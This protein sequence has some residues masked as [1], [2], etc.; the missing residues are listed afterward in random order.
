M[1]GAFFSLRVGGKVS[2]WNPHPRGIPAAA[3]HGADGKLPGG[4][5]SSQPQGDHGRGGVQPRCGELRPWDEGCG[6]LRPTTAHKFRGTQF[7]SV[8]IWYF[9]SSVGKKFGPFCGIIWMNCELKDP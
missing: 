1:F 2:G 3:L 5:D 9:C 8:N 4:D 6:G 7:G